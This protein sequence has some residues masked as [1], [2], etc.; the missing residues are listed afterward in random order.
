MIQFYLSEDCADLLAR[1][2]QP[3]QP[4]QPGAMQWHLHCATVAQQHCI[5]AMELQSSYVMVFCGLDKKAFKNFPTIF[6]ERFWREAMVL[7]QMEYQLTTEQEQALAG[8]SADIVTGQIYQMVD[9]DLV[10]AA[11]TLAIN[12]AV[13]LLRVLVENNGLP[14]PVDD[15]NAVMFGLRANANIRS[16]PGREAWF[17]PQEEY[18][19]FWLGLLEHLAAHPSSS[20]RPKGNIINVDF[21]A[22]KKVKS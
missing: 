6:S 8:C 21:S 18:R 16:S 20:G 7:V 11:M 9:D 17:Y 10:A 4:L 19:A 22:R 3:S 15:D 13:E 14:L 12:D 1:H 5:F 2:I